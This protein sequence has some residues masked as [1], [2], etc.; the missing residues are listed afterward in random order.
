MP[1][2][3]SMSLN[4]YR[5]ALGLVTYDKCY[6]I[7]PIEPS[8]SH[9]IIDMGTL[10]RPKREALGFYHPQDAAIKLGMPVT[11]LHADRKPLSLPPIKKYP[12]TRDS[13]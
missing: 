3:T 2:S 8:G 4:E 1:E 12:H 10:D 13:L 6:V 5:G 9:E 7:G 11:F